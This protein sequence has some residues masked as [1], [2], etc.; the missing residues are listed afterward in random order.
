MA[1]QAMRGAL[2]SSK[3][4]L[5]R[6]SLVWTAQTSHL[7]HHLAAFGERAAKARRRCAQ[8]ECSKREGAHKP[9]GA[10]TEAA[11]I[12]TLSKRPACLVNRGS[13]LSKKL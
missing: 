6:S 2:E 10:D 5:T 9:R 3:E 1:S 4:L 11:G 7:S 13:N 12:A 8:H